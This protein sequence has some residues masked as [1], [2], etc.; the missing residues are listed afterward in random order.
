MTTLF[1][2]GKLSG[3]MLIGVVYTMDHDVNNPLDSR[4]RQLNMSLTPRFV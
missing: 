3:F 1:W 4:F 2:Y